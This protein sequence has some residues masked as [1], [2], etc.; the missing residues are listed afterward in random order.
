M[1]FDAI[2]FD[3]DNTAI[4]G[5]VDG[6]PS[7]RL[8]D[9][10]KRYR[11]TVKLCAA[12]GRSWP[13]AKPVIEALGLKLPCIINGGTVIIDPQKAAILWQELLSLETAQH[14]LAVAQKYPYRVSYS[15]DLQVTTVQD[16]QH[17]SITAPINTFYILDFPPD[18]P[19]IS[20]ITA[21]LDQIP[22]I[23]V[24]KAG[25]WYVPDGIDLHVTSSQATKEHAVTE[26]SKM[27]NVS[28]EKIAGVGD[29]FND[30]H[31]FNA[32]GHKVAMGN[33]VSELKAEADEVVASREEDGLADFI[34]AAAAG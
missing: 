18:A 13:H 8:I 9:V 27:L 29:G 14:I 16:A 19:E 28:K 30:L 11:E 23:T 12:T 34:E 5:V 7:T 3:L 22:G 26:L 6:M 32:V 15:A 2:I 25:S 33:A 4:P 20:Q 24:T 10:V 17:I 31:L 1:S 21:E